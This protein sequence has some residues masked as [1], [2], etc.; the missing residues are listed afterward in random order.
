[1][2]T[3]SVGGSWRAAWSDRGFRLRA[4]LTAPALVLT[5]M[6]LARFL[7]QNELREGVVLADPVLRLF[8]PADVTWVTFG[9]IYLGL[10]VAVGSLL[11]HPPLLLLAVQTYIVMVVFRIIAMS[12]L[13]LEPPPTM[14][15]L[16]DPLVEYV[17]TGKLLTKDL[18][19]SGHTSTL[20]LLF[21]VFPAGRMKTLFLICTVLV[22]V[23][24]VLQHVHYTIDVFAAPF[25]AFAAYRIAQRLA[26]GTQQVK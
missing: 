3:T 7:E 2:T 19:F 22:A 11:R 14:I 4:L 21:L 12:L 6:V 25:F 17:G 1:M 23:C 16:Q 9:F 10:V 5:L 24:V 26:G 13:P 8:A 18:F 15:P 20:F